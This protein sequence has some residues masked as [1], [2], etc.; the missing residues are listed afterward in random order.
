M[1][2]GFHRLRCRTLSIKSIW[3][4]SQIHKI[5]AN[6]R[7]VGC[8]CGSFVVVA[9]GCPSRKHQHLKCIEVTEECQSC[10][11]K[12]ET[13][14]K[15]KQNKNRNY[16]MT[17]MNGRFSANIPIDNTTMNTI[18]ILMRMYIH[19]TALTSFHRIMHLPLI[20]CAP[21]FNE[22][23]SGL[24]CFVACALGLAL[25]RTANVWNLSW[26]TKVKSNHSGHLAVLIF[27]KCYK[28]YTYSKTC[29]F[30]AIYPFYFHGIFVRCS[31]SFLFIRWIDTL[32]YC[33]VCG[34]HNTKQSRTLFATRCIGS[35]FTGTCNGFF[36]NSCP[37][38]TNKN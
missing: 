25:A 20:P 26:C 33:S 36:Y 27:V 17:T 9:I 24:P 1:W 13:Q 5:I 22:L 23:K 7:E 21:L 29:P 31:R 2:R 38:N 10:D 32:L 30:S 11:K 18:A 15:R 12:S 14:S 6:V 8:C 28:S 3:T 34:L 35:R 37:L 4:Q 19:C 16:I